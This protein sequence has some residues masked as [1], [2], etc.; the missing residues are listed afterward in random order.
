MIGIS[1]VFRES[2]L[3]EL[4]RLDQIPI[5][6]FFELLFEHREIKTEH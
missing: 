3:T 2:D 1:G 5:A 6:N 4:T